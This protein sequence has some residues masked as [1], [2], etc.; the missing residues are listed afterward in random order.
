ML[1]SLS[2]VIVTEMERE[3]QK[4]KGKEERERARERE[5]EREKEREGRSGDEDCALDWG[6]GSEDSV[7]RV[8]RPWKK[9]GKADGMEVGL[10][11]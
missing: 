3:R 6:S 11:G 2:W 4:E 8:A 1:I 9:G 10:L 5:T 7:E